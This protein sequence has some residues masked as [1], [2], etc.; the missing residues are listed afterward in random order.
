MKPLLPWIILGLILRL[1]LIPSY[2]HPD[3]KGFNFGAFLVS[4]K[5]QLLTFYDYLS[6]LPPGHQLVQQYHRDLF[7]YPPL[8]YLTP[9]VFMKLLSPLYPWPVFNQFIFDAGNLPG[10]SQMILLTYLLKS[11]YLLADLFCLWLI[12]RLSGLKNRFLAGLF[13]IF[14]PV[15][16]YSTYLIGQ[17]DIYLVAFVLL[18]LY[19]SSVSRP[20]LAAVTLGLTA[21]FKPFPLFFLPFLPG[22]KVKNAILGLSAYLLV[23]LPYLLSPGFRTYALLASQS[24]KI[25]FAKV[26]VSASQYLP[27]FFV[28]LVFLIWKHWQNPRAFPVYIWMAAVCLLFY[29]LSHFHPQ[30]F[31]WTTPF[32]V[33]WAANSPPARLPILTLVGLYFALVL[34]FEPS[35]NFQIFRLDFSLSAWLDKFHLAEYFASALRGAFAATSLYLLTTVKTAHPHD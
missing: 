28:G 16:L 6:S 10:S 15:T 34:T 33:L 18:A 35:L 11:P 30:W 2:V 13:W 3:L 26:M 20:R 27:L 29:A 1:A 25:Q 23:L 4:Q 14:N 8:A 32:L 9:A 24:E 19:F 22:S 21:A 17:F 31:L 5:S 12:T 7:I